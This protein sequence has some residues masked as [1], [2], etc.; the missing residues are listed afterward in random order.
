MFRDATTGE[1]QGLIKSM[2]MDFRRSFSYT[3]PTCPFLGAP[4]VAKKTKQQHEEELK[5]SLYQHL[6]E[7]IV[8]RS[9]EHIM[10]RGHLEVIKAEKVRR[11]RPSHTRAHAHARTHT[12]TRARS[13]SV[14][15]RCLTPHLLTR[16]WPGRLPT[17]SS[18]F[19]RKTL[20]NSSTVVEPTS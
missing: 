1:L 4:S 10:R 19:L 2:G 7:A 20:S 12:H 14:T 5:S 18:A 13:F 8:S 16:S 6:K 3:Q 17:L 9:A 15:H 11:P